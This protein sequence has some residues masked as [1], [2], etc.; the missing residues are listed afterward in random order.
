MSKINSQVTTYMGIKLDTLRASWF[1]RTED[2]QLVFLSSRAE[3][4]HA[5]RTG[6]GADGTLWVAGSVSKLSTS[7]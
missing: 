2:D 6:L 4:S 5:D 7:V 3:A 1:I